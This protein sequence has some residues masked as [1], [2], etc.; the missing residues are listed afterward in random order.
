MWIVILRFG[1]ESFHFL[2]FLWVKNDHPFAI[3]KRLYAFI[4]SPRYISLLVPRLE[5]VNPF[6]AVVEYFYQSCL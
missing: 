6:P 1:Y 3:L 4:N 5:A 2:K